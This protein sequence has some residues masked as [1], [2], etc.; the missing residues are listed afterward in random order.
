MATRQHAWTL[1]SGTLL[2]DDVVNQGT[3]DVNGDRNENLEEESGDLEEDIILN[4][5]DNVCNLVAGVNMENNSTT[6]S[7]EKSTTGEQCSGQSR[8]K[9]K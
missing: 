1:F 8:K 7:S 9:N 4:Y 6:N 2:D 5:A 3:Q